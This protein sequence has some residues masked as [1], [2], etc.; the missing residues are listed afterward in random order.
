LEL[1]F[2]RFVDELRRPPVFTGWLEHP[3]NFAMSLHAEGLSMVREGKTYPVSSLKL[4]LT[5]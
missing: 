4:L 5:E 1:I 3:D 2:I